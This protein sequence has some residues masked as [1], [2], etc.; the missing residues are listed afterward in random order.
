M[1]IIS[2]VPSITETLLS[3]GIN[4][5]G[6]SR[7]CIHPAKQ[8]N[9]IAK[10]GGT[11][12]VDWQKIS[13]LHVDLVIL[14]KEENTLS[15]A[16]TCPFD[17]FALHITGIQ[18]VSPELSRLAD[19]LNNNKLALIAQR[20]QKIAMQP[21]QFDLASLPGVMQWWRLPTTHSKFIYLIWQE[22]WMA[23]G[24]NT[25]I[26]SVLD[27][28]GV[29]S[30]RVSFS[31]KY[32]VIELADYATEE[33]CLLFSSEPFPFARHREKLEKLGY[34]CALVDGEKYSWYGIRSLEFLE[35]LTETESS[36][37]V[38]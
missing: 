10:V 30:Q 8:V 23:I 34:A 13:H 15:M 1:R 37:S 29:E 17:Y 16:E 22:P 24:E 7:F 26:Q 5:V 3:C 2:L 25:F 4:V 11:K 20:W 31:A 9:Q 19:R 36:V 14:D 27:H 12:D 38:D 33:T 28:I 32:P 18:D 35:S 21:M 6:R